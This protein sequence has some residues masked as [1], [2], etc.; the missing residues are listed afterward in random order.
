MGR[1][2]FSKEYLDRL[3]KMIPGLSCFVVYLGVNKD[4]TKDFPKGAHNILKNVSYNAVQSYKYIR[5]G[6][7][8]KMPFALLNFSCVRKVRNVSLIINPS[9]PPSFNLQILLTINIE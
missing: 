7:V 4:Y 6:N 5:E 1:E 3:D 9:F 8:D 2:H